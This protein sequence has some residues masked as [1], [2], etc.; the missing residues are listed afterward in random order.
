[1]KK[2]R[3]SRSY[4]HKL[5]DS[6][7]REKRLVQEARN[8]VKLRKEGVPV[9]G[10]IFVDTISCSLYMEYVFPSMSLKN[11]F[12]DLE[13]VPVPTMADFAGQMGKSIAVLHNCQ[14]IHGDLTTSNFLVKPD[15]SLTT[16]ILADLSIGDYLAKPCTVYLI[17]FGLSYGSNTPEDMAVDLHVLE[18][19]ISSAHPQL[20]TFV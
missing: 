16:E 8:M 1:M 10:L 19:A 7:I 2:E 6:K 17:D 13:N 18:K 9:P 5:L 3:I 15:L 20:E 11:F 14:C 12:I 4:R